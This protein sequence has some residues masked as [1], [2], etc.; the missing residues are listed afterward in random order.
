MSNGV[1]VGLHPLT[2]ALWLIA[3]AVVITLT[4][5]PFYLLVLLCGLALTV[6]RLRT[7]GRTAPIDPL[8]FAALAVA[9]GG[10]FNMLTT[11][12]GETVL[13]RLPEPWP[14]VGG[15]L[16]A[17]ALVYGMTNGL[18]LGALVAAFAVFGIALPVGALLSLT[19]RAFY[20][21]AVVTTIAVTYVP[22]TLRHAR[23]VREAQLLR[24]HQVRGWRDTLPLVL[25]LLIGGLERAL[26]LAEALAARGFAAEAPPP[27]TR[28][29]LAGGLTA[30]FGGLLL[31]FAWGQTVGPLAI[32]GG[33]ALV[34]AALVLAGRRTPRTHYQ[35]YTW[36]GRDVLTLSGAVL[37]LAVML[38]PWPARASIVFAPY[39]RLAWPMFEPFLA[40]GLLG[41]FMPAGLGLGGGTRVQG[42]KEPERP[43]VYR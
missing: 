41:L 43:E 7:P 12:Y 15:P 22:L 37:A 2:W 13:L 6:E 31:H 26:Q 10:L 40:L 36:R 24:G 23:Q 30:I 11:H 42:D 29:L 39:P 16:T 3:A 38:L 20:P 8:L 4:R 33:A 25:P 28:I 27:F 14:L 35:Q 19:P 32:G 17:E 34:I 9:F 1:A 5:N 21:L 18:V